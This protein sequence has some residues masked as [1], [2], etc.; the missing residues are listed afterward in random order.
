MNSRTSRP[1]SPISASTV[2]GASVPRVIMESK[3]RLADTGA[4]EDAHA[5]PAAARHERVDRAHAERE[6]RV[7]HAARQRVRRLV[8]DRARAERRAATG[9]PSIGRPRPSSTRPSSSGPTG[10]ER[11]AVGF[12]GAVAGADAAEIA[13]RHAH[14]LVVADRD[15]FGD[16]GPEVGLDRDR[17]ADR[18]VQ[19]DDLEVEPEHARDATRPRA[20]GRRR[21]RR[22]AS[23]LTSS[24]LTGSRAS[25][26]GSRV[27]DRA[28]AFDRRVEAG[29]DAAAVHVDDAVARA[30]GPA[31]ATSASERPG[32]RSAG[33]PS[34]A[35]SSG[36]S[37][38]TTWPC[39][40]AKS[41]R[42]CERVAARLA[43]VRELVAD[44]HLRDLERDRRRPGPRC[45][46][47]R[48]LRG[49]TSWLAASASCGT[50][51]MSRA[52]RSSV[53]EPRLGDAVGVAR[54]VAV[55]VSRAVAVADRALDELGVDDERA[56]DA[57]R[58]L[59]E[60][61]RRG[62]RMTSRSTRAPWCA[63]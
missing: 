43:R 15:D 56:G 39:S 7:D 44:E 21:A 14:E 12:V 52:A 4:G 55:V 9:P 16:H 10:I 29:V 30:R 23:R 58:H 34:A 17:A 41:Q 40:G 24:P 33:S 22:R 57:R 32:A 63:P 51:P 26:P 46:R 28:D 50:S 5:L 13:E 11:G 49:R 47:A 37:R 1:R 62:H 45:R 31:S 42:A 6:L 25:V 61:G 8:L 18:Q 60:V 38:A 27:Q 36:C 35:R 48:S 19:A 2:T 53:R 54:A 59:A 3:R 20:A